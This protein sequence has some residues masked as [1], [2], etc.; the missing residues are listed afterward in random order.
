MININVG[1]NR[2][3]TQEGTIQG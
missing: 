3:G 1:E 2:R